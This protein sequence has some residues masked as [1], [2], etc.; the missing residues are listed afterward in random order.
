MSKF[1][2]LLA[3]LATASSA[4]VLIAGTIPSP[5]QR[6]VVKLQL[7]WTPGSEH[8]FLYAGV[9]E[10][11]FLDEGIDLQIIP[12]TGSSGSVA[13]VDAKT[14]QFALCSGETALQARSA[15]PPRDVVAI[16]VFYPN[17]PTVVYSLKKA[18]I[19]T[20]ADLR[21]KRVGVVLGSSAYRNFL[22]YLRVKGI[23]TSEMKLVATSGDV[24][25]VWPGPGMKSELDAMVHFGFQH[26]LLLR[27]KK[28]EV[29]ELRLADEPKVRVAG[30]ALITRSEL[31][32][33]RFD[34]VR[35]VT[36]AVQKS[37]R[38]AIQHPSET[39]R[40]FHD[41]IPAQDRD[42]SRA[43]LNWTNDFVARGVQVGRAIGWQ[44]STMWLGTRNYL[45]DLGLLKRDVALGAFWYND[46][47]DT[48]VV[49]KRK[50]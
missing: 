49:L 2:R 9:R 16:A 32:E 50:P 28:V 37:Y 29:N 5:V 14:V 45:R 23:D 31:V 22:A 44:D 10:R 48:S 25:E 40:Y 35:R 30:Q 11:F 26:P 21:G 38:F 19:T 24:R 39:L 36:R 27:L 6:E 17:T 33:K 7:D 1:A 4:G 42:Y 41:Q 3:T 12:G 20:A 46:F 43:K 34:L 18:G 47:I 15:E 8:A 13:A